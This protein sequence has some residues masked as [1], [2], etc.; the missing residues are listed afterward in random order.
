MPKAFKKANTNRIVKRIK[1]G[2]MLMEQQKRAG[3]RK[4]NGRYGMLTV[5]T[6]F[7]TIIGAIFMAGCISPETEQP[8]DQAKITFDEAM[9]IAQNSDCVKD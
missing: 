5:I 3:K 2:V 7:V 9:E 1:I 4:K 8:E 6:L